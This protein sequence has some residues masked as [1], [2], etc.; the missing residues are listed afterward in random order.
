MAAYIK[1]IYVGAKIW[2][3]HHGKSRP[4]IVM[5]KTDGAKDI[6]KYQVLLM[7]RQVSIH[8]HANYE[9]EVD[10]N[11]HLDRMRELD[12]S[13]ITGVDPLFP[14]EDFEKIKEAYLTFAGRSYQYGF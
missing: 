8:L 5:F 13:E 12:I 10:S 3:P 1:K 11:I 6:Q 7:S 9:Y 14:K 4:H 2:A